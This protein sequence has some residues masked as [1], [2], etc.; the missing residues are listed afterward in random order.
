MDI[1]DALL[2]TLGLDHNQFDVGS[3]QVE[4]QIDELRVHVTNTANEIEKSTEGL[5]EGLL[6][7]AEKAAG[8][9]GVAF[10]FYELK[11]KI[12][13]T[14]QAYVDL[15]KL[16]EQFHTTTEALEEYS[17]AGRLLGLSNEVTIGSLK[18][19]D[20]AVQDTALGL[21]RAKKIFEELGI[22][23]KDAAGNVK[24]TT[25]VMAELAAKFKGMERGKQLRIM[26]RLGLNPA[27]LKMFN[28]DLGDMQKRLDD[29]DKATGFSLD[30]AT[31]NSAEFTKSL[32]GLS[33]EVRTVSMYFEKLFETAYIELMP[34]IADAMDEARGYVAEFLEFIE[35][36]KP[37]VVGVF[38][39]IAAAVT[40][41]VIP[42]LV[43]AA[44]A[45][46]AAV[47]PFIGIGL[48]IAAVIAIFALLY[49][50]WQTWMNGGKSELGELWEF[51]A[52]I[53][54]KIRDT[55]L[56][57]FEDVK[58]V[59]METFGVLI[60][61]VKFIAALFTGSSDDIARTWRDLC[62]KL[63]ELFADVGELLI[64]A[65]E[66]SSPSRFRGYGT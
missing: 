41:F 22:S 60:A 24:P 9:L 63:V 14:A 25:Q 54:P 28:A 12:E 52:S 1:V 27:L 17:E 56:T 57:V 66:N 15:G 10:S 4:K 58:R 39:A 65:I 59:G 34:V 23:V 36:H 61:A 35:E 51:F 43:E 2:V 30:K 50:D 20:R 55:V 32:K 62:G 13:E 53:W 6:S 64:A 7:F 45:A 44:V 5:A 11:D 3:A 29:I 16:A 42:S 19:L 21:G 48:A 37:F 40:Y 8:V 33:L 31:K 47:A 38:M 46:W 49:D 18:D 26:E